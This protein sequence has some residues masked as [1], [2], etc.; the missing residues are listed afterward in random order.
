MGRF[1]LING[2]KKQLKASV[3]ALAFYFLGCLVIV[4]PLLL[5][6]FLSDNKKS[7][8]GPV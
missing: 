7:A 1:S 3:D 2:C 4:T 6:L 5:G 8:V